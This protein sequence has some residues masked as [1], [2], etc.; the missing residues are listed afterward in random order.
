MLLDFIINITY[1]NCLIFRIGL[2]VLINFIAF[3]IANFIVVGFM[4]NFL[5]LFLGL[6]YLA[7]VFFT[8]IIFNDYLSNNSTLYSNLL[9]YSLFIIITC[10]IYGT[11]I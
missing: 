11:Y 2:R 4:R 3:M 1:F 7:N 6:D 9:I 8:N 10:F 5:N